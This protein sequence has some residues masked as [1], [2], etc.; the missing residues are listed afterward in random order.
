M[1]YPVVLT[2][3]G[4]PGFEDLKRLSDFLWPASC[5][6]IQAVAGIAGCLF[7]LWCIWGCATL[8][9]TWCGFNLAYA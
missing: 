9:K 2:S 5:F 3:S 1:S 7:W 4:H 6:M 8:L